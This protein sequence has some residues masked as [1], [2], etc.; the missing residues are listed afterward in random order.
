MQLYKLT[1]SKSL[2]TFLYNKKASFVEYCGFVSFAILRSFFYVIFPFPF[3]I[4]SPT[5]LSR[6]SS[7][8]PLLL[9]EFLSFPSTSKLTLHSREA[10]LTPFAAS[11]V[12][13]QITLQSTSLL[14][15]FFHEVY[16]L[17]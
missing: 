7:L 13:S 3:P 12:K 9:F 6:S 16:L 2:F 1:V 17:T 15:S 5:S 14:L 8:L 10:H 4:L 11:G